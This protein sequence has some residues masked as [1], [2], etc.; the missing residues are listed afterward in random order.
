MKAKV[1]IIVPVFNAESYLRRCLD[2]IMHQRY[3]NFEVLLIDD[4]STDS[5]GMICDEYSNDSRFHVFHQ[6][7]QGQSVARNF[8]LKHVT[9]KY[10]LFVDADD[11]IADDLLLKVVMCMEKNPAIDLVLFNHS[12][13][14]DKGIVPF[15][16]DFER[17]KIFLD[18]DNHDS[19]YR[20]ILMNKISN[21]IWDK[22]Y[23]KEIWDNVQFPAGYYY[24]DLFI[25]PKL[26]ENVHKIEFLS[27]PLYFNNRIN[28]N[29][30]TSELNDFNSFN[31]YSKFRAF[32]EHETMAIKHGDIQAANWARSQA[33]HEGIKALYID[34]ES[35]KKM[36]KV[37]KEDIL[38][39]IKLKDY[40]KEPYDIKIKFKILKWASFYCPIVCKM[41]GKLRFKQECLKNR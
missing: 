27:E 35:K 33:V 13:I 4:G 7:N 14:T 41:Y 25:H 36:K 24:E 18:K 19:F 39:Y 28:P 8:A 12:E 32:C 17:E 38:S 23:K 40:N 29:S 5:S 16:H 20:L 31:R 30:T 3:A 37:E 22:A 1:S 9:G 11:Y 34:Y 26:F 6:K 15:I 2:S 10:I 21:L